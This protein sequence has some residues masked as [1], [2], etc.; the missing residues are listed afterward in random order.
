[1][2]EDITVNSIKV[3]A[4]NESSNTND[5]HMQ[6]TVN[7]L[8]NNT[9]IKTRDDCTKILLDRIYLERVNAQYALKGAYNLPASS[10]HW[11]AYMQMTF[12]SIGSLA[13]DLYEAGVENVTVKNVSHGYVR[14]VAFDNALMMNVKNPN[15]I[16]QEYCPHGLNCPNQ[17][18]GVEIIVTFN[19]SPTTPGQGISMENV[20][21]TYMNQLAQASC[22][23]VQGKTSILFSCNYINSFQLK[24]C[25]IVTLHYNISLSLSL[26]PLR[27]LTFCIILWTFFFRNL[28]TITTIYGS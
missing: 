11:Y 15:I 4:P 8:I 22:T 20:Q 27:P 19:C 6:R 5:I 17:G 13:K 26:S 28:K 23:H 10:Y 7:I 3:R 9:S 2:G 1:M 12:T 18:S 14:G 25:F 24:I 16:D 21:L